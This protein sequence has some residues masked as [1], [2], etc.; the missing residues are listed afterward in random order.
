MKFIVKKQFALEST[1]QNEGDIVEMEAS[2]AKSFVESDSVAE[3]VEQKTVQ[4]EV[5]S[6]A[7]ADAVREGLSS[8][9]PKVEV[10]EEKMGFGEFLQGIA[11]KTINITTN[12]N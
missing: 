8:Y 5:D 2:D 6:K 1:V 12:T 10:V 4:V 7:I 11:K 3:Y 9:A